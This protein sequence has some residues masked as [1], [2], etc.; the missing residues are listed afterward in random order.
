MDVLDHAGIL[1]GILSTHYSELD[2]VISEKVIT[3]RAN[4]YIDFAIEAAK[5]MDIF[6]DEEDIRETISF[7]KNHQRMQ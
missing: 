2:V 5:K 7:W 6:K 4:G 1:E 3:S